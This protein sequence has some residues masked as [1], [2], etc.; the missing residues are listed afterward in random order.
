MSHTI[1]LRGPWTLKLAAP[2]AGV[3]PRPDLTA[4]MPATLAQAGWPGV[5]GIVEATRRFQ[6]VYHLAANDRVDLVIPGVSGE[7]RAVMLNGGS[8]PTPTGAGPWR[9]PVGPLLLASNILSLTLE[10]AKDE[11]GLPDIIFLEITP[12]EPRIPQD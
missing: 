9:W 4:A 1:R 2:A 8:L 11:D 10:T 3:A 5:A 7:L 12:A 6:W